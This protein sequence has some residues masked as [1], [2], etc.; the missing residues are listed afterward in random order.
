MLSFLLFDVDV[1]DEFVAVVY[2]SWIQ[3]Q[4]VWA[5]TKFNDKMLSENFHRVRNVI[6]IFS[7]EKSGAF[8]GK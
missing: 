8:Q 6:L 5:T 2:A 3:F 1:A 7:V 4:N